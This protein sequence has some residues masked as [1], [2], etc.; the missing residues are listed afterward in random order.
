MAGPSAAGP[1]SATAMLES[2]AHAID[3]SRRRPATVPAGPSATRAP[4]SPAAHG[5]GDA[6]CAAGDTRPG[7]S[8]APGAERPP[9]RDP[10]DPRPPGLRWAHA[11]RR[12]GLRDGRGRGRRVQPR[13]ARSDGPRGDRL[14]RGLGHLRPQRQDRAGPHLL[15]GERRRVIEW[16]GVPPILADAITAVEDK[17]FWTNTGIDPLGIVSAAIDTLTGDARGASTITQQLVRQKLLPDDVMQE[18]TASASAR[19]RSSSS[20]SGSPTPTAAARARR[21]SSPRTSTRTST[22]TTATASR[23]PPSPTSASP[24]STT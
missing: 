23:R 21:P 13:P 9:G 16:Q 10:A 17:T 18:S 19:S 2:L 11:P 5:A 14:S 8:A 7:A 4:A 6:A 22:A 1:R 15:G 12:A 3:A 24:T 20:R